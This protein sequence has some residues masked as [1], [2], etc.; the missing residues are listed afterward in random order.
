M[1]FLINDS[2][3]DGDFKGANAMYCNYGNY[4]GGNGSGIGYDFVDFTIDCG[5]TNL[6][7]N[8]SEGVVT[9][10]VKIE[11]LDMVTLDPFLKSNYALFNIDLNYSE[12]SHEAVFNSLKSYTFRATEVNISSS[13]TV[14]P[15]VEITGVRIY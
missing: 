3:D 14:F 13:G 1:K 10:T 2:W 4:F 8:N 5:V 12:A 11:L 7:I 9:V 6:D 15:N